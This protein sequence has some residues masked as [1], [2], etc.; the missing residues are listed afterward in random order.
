MKWTRTLA[1]KSLSQSLKKPLLTSLSTVIENKKNDMN[2]YL[3][4]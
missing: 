1:I 3:E 4:D 2:E